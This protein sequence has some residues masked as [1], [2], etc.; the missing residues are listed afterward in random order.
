MQTTQ[1]F[2]K[3]QM[4]F[5]LGMQSAGGS[6]T[7]V[8]NLLAI[9]V[10]EHA[11]R[12]MF[13]WGPWV[14]QQCRRR[15]SG[16]P[17]THTILTSPRAAIECERTFANTNNK[18]QAPAQYS[19]RMDA[20]VNYVTTLPAMKTLLSIPQHDYLPYEFDPVCL[21]PDIYFQLKDLKHNDGVLEFIRFKLV[22]YEPVSYTHLRAHETLS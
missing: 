14:L 10:F 4:M 17:T 21:G 16:E 19:T 3:N 6:W 5:S 20:V 7:A 18:Q 8:K 15:R 12:A 1:D 22:C 9:Q 2:I 13:T 11:T